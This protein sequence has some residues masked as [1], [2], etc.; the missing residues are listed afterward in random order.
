MRPSR[1]IYTALEATLDLYRQ[2]TAK[3]IAEIPTLRNLLA[4]AE[5]VKKRAERLTEQLHSLPCVEATLIPCRSQAG[6]GALPTRELASWGV[7]LVPR[8]GS[9]EELAYKLRMG[10]P[11]IVTRRVDDS[12]TLDARTIRDDE[13]SMIAQRLRT[14]H[15][16]RT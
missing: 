8:D 4:D 6:S 11:S 5:E 15:A 14:L 16:G 13:V 9:S 3:A 7:R 12:L 10:D 1:F 2:G